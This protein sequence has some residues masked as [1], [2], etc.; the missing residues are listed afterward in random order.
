MVAAADGLAVA[1]RALHAQA[2]NPST[3]VIARAVGNISHTTVSE[4]LNGTRVSS[5]DLV[6]QVGRFFGADEEE[7]YKLWMAAKNSS[8]ALDATN[9]IWDPMYLDRIVTT[10]FIRAKGSIEER[11]TERTITATDN[12]VDRY[13]ARASAPKGEGPRVAI[14]ALLNCTVG[15]VRDLDDPSGLL[16]AQQTDL[17]LPEMLNVGDQCFFATRTRFSHSMWGSTFS[18][19]E[20]TGQGAGE[21]VMR[22]QFSEDSVPAVCWSFAGSAVVDSFVRPDDGSPDILPIS[23][24]GYVETTFHGIPAGARVAIVW[25]WK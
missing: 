17:M 22:V 14:E 13:V 9:S 10:S 4:M 8:R 12:S 25:R 1:L 19:I 20:I 15:E 23:R 18:R 5:W 2:G 16:S 21:V 7:L 11:I 3:R 24:C 6:R